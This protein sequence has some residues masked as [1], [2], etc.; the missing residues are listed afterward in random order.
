MTMY[1]S[2]FVITNNTV[3]IQSSVWPFDPDFSAPICW[4]I[5]RARR[6]QGHRRRRRG[7]GASVDRAAE[8]SAQMCKTSCTF[9]RRRW[10]HC[11]GGRCWCGLKWCQRIENDGPKLFWGLLQVFLQDL[12]QFLQSPIFSPCDQLD[13]HVLGISCIQLGRSLRWVCVTITTT[14]ASER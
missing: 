7:F 1:F 6:V 12:T 13:E 10:L 9:L 8:Y 14:H 11:T 2:T 5:L 3:S 4:C